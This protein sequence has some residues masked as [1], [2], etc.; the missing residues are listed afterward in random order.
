MEAGQMRIGLVAVGSAYKYGE[1]L[2][3]EVP[4]ME[5]AH[6]SVLRTA[7]AV[8]RQQAPPD[9]GVKMSPYYPQFRIQKYYELSL[10]VSTLHVLPKAQ[11]HM[12]S[13]QS[14]SAMALLPTLSMQC[15]SYRQTMTVP[16]HPDSLSSHILATRHLLLAQHQAR[17]ACCHT[18]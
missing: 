12:G 1:P 10:Y 3:A 4:E 11:R 2:H 8:R 14:I 16:K 9:T 7:V 15:P 18:P 6:C 5:T 17:L 13:R